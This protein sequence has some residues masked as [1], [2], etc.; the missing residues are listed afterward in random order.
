[1]PFI[2]TMS[3]ISNTL[4]VH[5][6]ESF[7]THDGPGIRMVIFLQ[8]CNLKCAYCHNPDTIALKGGQQVAIEE[9]VSRAVNLK[10]YFGNTGGVTASGGEP[11]LQAKGLYELFR[12]LKKNEIHTNIDTNGAVFN[13]DVRQLLDD[14]ADL[15]MIDIKHTDS[16]GYQK[17]T[18]VRDLNTAM[19]LATH[20]EE[21]GKPFWLRYVL[22]PGITSQPDQL[23]KLGREWGKFEML[24]KIE[25]QPYHQLGVHKWVGL[26]W[27]YS[28]K[29][30]RQNTPDEIAQAIN[31]LSN[32]FKEVKA[33]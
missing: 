25:I 13:N 23:H 8:G 31:I 5:S 9:L 20:R 27:D 15:V 16:E 32:Y 1:M 2:D 10:S 24:E 17:L 3:I 11:L 4:N 14:Y 12:E 28:M 26:G 33:N 19:K 30:V 7:G 29:D 22:I 21:S 18:T 6:I